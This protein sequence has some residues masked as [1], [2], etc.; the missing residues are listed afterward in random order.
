MI[1]SQ[2]TLSTLLGMFDPADARTWPSDTV[3][4]RGGLG[5]V[6]ELRE[7]VQRDGSWSVRCRPFVPLRFLAGSVR[8]GH[9]RW[10][11]LGVVLA[12]GGTVVPTDQE[13]DPPYHCELAGLT[14]EQFDSILGW[15]EPNPVAAG[16]R[17][18]SR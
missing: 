4:L 1:A 15:P 8:N 5:G 11:A 14:P 3:V 2:A 6:H 7:T 9:I 17:W 13:G 16:D 10:A 12:L 18:R